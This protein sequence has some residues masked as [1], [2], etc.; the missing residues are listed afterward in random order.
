MIK[1]TYNGITDTISGWAARTEIPVTTIHSRFDYGWTPHRILTQPVRKYR[2][3]EGKHPMTDTKDDDLVKRAL[4][5]LD[6]MQGRVDA[7]KLQ[8]FQECID[9][10]EELEA[11]L[12]AERERCA[13]VTDHLENIL[14]ALGFLTGGDWELEGW[15][16]SQEEGAEIRKDLA[17]IR[18][19]DTP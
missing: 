6:D 15:G 16:I 7:T 14:D 2:S 1:I 3:T 17:A 8:V 12:A 19:G 5:A 9:R 10:I 11:K 4:H 13:K 18:E